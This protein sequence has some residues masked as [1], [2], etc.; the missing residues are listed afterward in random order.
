M[1]TR[2]H[3]GEDV[4]LRMSCAGIGIQQADRPRGPPRAR[5]STRRGRARADH[6]QRGREQA[7]RCAMYGL[8]RAPNAGETPGAARAPGPGHLPRRRSRR[9][10][11]VEELLAVRYH[12]RLILLWAHICPTGARGG[13]CIPPSKEFTRAR[14]Q[15]TLADCQCAL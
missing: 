5:S 15:D 11:T 8:E 2:S 6:V 14:P 1:R 3:S 4:W 7:P 9:R 10:E 12:K 13:T